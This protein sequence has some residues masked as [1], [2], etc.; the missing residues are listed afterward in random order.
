VE[1]LG[2]PVVSQSLS[3]KSILYMLLDFS[4]IPYD[5]G[6]WSTSVSIDSICHSR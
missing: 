1:K 2:L 6:M 3:R 5:P 4:A